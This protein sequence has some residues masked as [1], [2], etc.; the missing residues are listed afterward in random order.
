MGKITA[1]NLSII[2]TA[3]NSSDNYVDHYIMQRDRYTNWYYGYVVTVPSMTLSDIIFYDLDDYNQTTDT[4]AQVPESV[5]IYLYGKVTV[6]AN[7]TYHLPEH[8]VTNQEALWPIY[9]IEDKD[10][11]V[12]IPDVDGDGVW[13]NTEWGYQE[14]KDEL[15]QNG[16]DYYQKGY[17]HEG[18][19]VNL[20]IVE[21]P[22][23]VKILGNKGGYR[24]YACNTALN[25]ANGDTRVS[26]GLYHG[27]AENW[28]GFY[29]STKFYYSETEYYQGPPKDNEKTPAGEEIYVFFN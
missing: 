26:N 15:N 8:S 20:N 22:G 10:G 24:Y 17:S 28:K 7:S 23:Y 27:A 19:A 3:K 4:Y 25:S 12:D 18:S 14:K 2:A 6:K 13:G 16:L 9:S 11:Y 29:G 5:P 21:P 1:K